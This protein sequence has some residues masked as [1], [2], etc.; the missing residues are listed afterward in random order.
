MQDGN[1]HVSRPWRSRLQ[2]SAPKRASQSIR[3]RARETNNEA[4]EKNKKGLPSQI[5]GLPENQQ[6][7]MLKKQRSAFQSNRWPLEEINN[8]TCVK[9]IVA[10]EREKQVATLSTQKGFP[11]QMR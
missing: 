10:C 2:L 1:D 9:N 8:E 3:W 4:C 5:D 11:I 7:S 6:R